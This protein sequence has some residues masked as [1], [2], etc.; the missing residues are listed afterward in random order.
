MAQHGCN[1]SDS[2][3]LADLAMAICWVWLHNLS[4]DS[5]S[6]DPPQLSKD[7]LRLH[8]TNSARFCWAFTPQTQPGF[9]EPSLHRY[10]MYKAQWLSTEGAESGI[11]TGMYMAQWLSAGR[12]CWVWLHNSQMLG[13][14]TQCR[15]GWVR[16]YSDTVYVQKWLGSLAEPIGFLKLVDWW[17]Y[18]SP[19]H[20]SSTL[21]LLI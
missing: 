9:A 15:R 2:Q 5:L 16:L 11:T 14:M 10:S 4:E 3:Q 18:E 17:A 8:S 21:Q 13:T 1:E 7:L 19:L 12:R 20:C 6:L